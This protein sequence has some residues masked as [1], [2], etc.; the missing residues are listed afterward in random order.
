MFISFFPCK[1]FRL[2]PSRCIKWN[3]F[4][5]KDWLLPFD[6]QDTVFPAHPSYFSRS[7]KSSSCFCIIPTGIAMCSCRNAI[8]SRINRHL[9]QQLGYILVSRKGCR[10]R[11]K[12][13]HGC[14][15]VQENLPL[16]IGKDCLN[17]GNGL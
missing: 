10:S 6:K 8:C 1:L 4:F 17:L 16:L 5:V 7:H 3:C 15:V 13:Y 14:T 11:T 2:F 12:I 9:S